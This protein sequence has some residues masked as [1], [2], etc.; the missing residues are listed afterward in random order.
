MAS[1]GIGSDERPGGSALSEINITPFVDV[2]LVLL[3][4]FLITAPM[5]LRGIDVKVPKTETKNVGPEERLMLTVTREK[6]VYLDGQPVTLVRLERA[7]VGLRQRNAK[8]AVFLRADEGVSY[9]VVV[10]VMDAVKKAG[11]ER[12]GMVTEPIP[13]VVKGQ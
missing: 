7:L 10:K 2:V 1:P 3:V 12:L 5:M 6:A 11:I 8:A 13:P 9:G 4:I